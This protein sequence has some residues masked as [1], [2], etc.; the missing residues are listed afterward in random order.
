MHTFALAEGPGFCNAVRRTLLSD[1]ESWAPCDVVVRENTSCQTDE[2]L[3]HRIGMI[4]FRRV[5]NGDTMTLRADGPG[6]ATAGMLTGP[7]FEP[8]HGNI[9]IMKLGGREQKLDLTVRFDRRKASVHARY[10]PCAAVGMRPLGAHNHEIRFE[11]NDGRPGKEAM[12]D[13]LEA[14]D[15]RVQAALHALANQ[16]EVPPR[17]MC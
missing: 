5:G 13:A 14:L 8:V 3:A 1:L 16:P 12:Q 17:S 9:E 6:M 11:T 2:F 7:A 10:A 15:A 4:P